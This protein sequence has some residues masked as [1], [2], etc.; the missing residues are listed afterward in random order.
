MTTA[1]DTESLRVVSDPSGSRAT[2]VMEMSAA[3]GFAAYFLCA[4]IL[5]TLARKTG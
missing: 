3:S 1:S 4:H 2:Y 5:A